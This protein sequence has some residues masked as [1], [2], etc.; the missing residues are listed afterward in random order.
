MNN[1]AID[2]KDFM[3]ADSVATRIAEQYMQWEMARRE[4]AAQK[5]ELRNY[6]F[7]IDTRT[8]NSK[9]LPWKNTTH[10]PKLCQIR[11][12][13][14]ANYM[15]A[16]FP[17]DRS[18]KWEGDDQEA[19]TLEK[20][21]VVEMYIRNKMHQSGFKNTMSQLLLDY[22]DT[23]NCFATVEYVRE[24]HEDPAT[25]EKILGY[26]G[27]K[28]YRI[29][30]NDIVF[31]PK[32]A[33]F[34]STAKI[35]RKLT[36]L[37]SLK[38]YIEKH[39][40]AEHLSGVFN[41]IVTNR[42]Q[43]NGAAQAD[44]AMSEAYAM[45]GFGTFMEYMQ[46]DYVEILTFYGD[47]YDR[48]TDTLYKNHKIVVVDRAYVLH[49]G[50]PQTWRGLPP[51]FHT[52]W[53]QRPDNLYAMGPLDNLVGMQHRIDH[54]E[55]AKA[56]AYDLIIHPVIKIKGLVEDFEYGP[57]ARIYVGDEGDA[58]FMR[59]DVT[60]LNADTQIMMYEAKMEEMAGAPKQAMGFRTPGEKTAYEVQV[61]EN[62]ANKVF[63][64]KAAHYEETFMEPILNAMLE[65][66]R[67]NMEGN[68]LVRTVDDQF[69]VVEF[70]KITKEDNTAKG[71]I[72][73]IGA[74]HFARN[75][76]IVQNLNAFMGSPLG[77]DPGVRNH[78]SGLRLARLMEELLDLERYDLVEENIQLD[79]A[80]ESQRRIGAIEQQLMEEGA[81]PSGQPAPPGTQNG[82][83]QGP[84]PRRS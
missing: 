78:L 58:E 24:E 59:P 69:N 79:E 6:L 46:S 55:N 1:V 31:D 27:P 25:S 37:P 49:K 56:D 81:I 44:F 80:A 71:K 38:A 26:V 3:N 8:T 72:R 19:E 20:R 10:L 16:I 17:H 21:K 63:I 39:P 2:I 45:D 50:P 35:I 42:H 5:R 68:E 76:N 84:Q 77:Q 73:P 70:Q 62:G 40:E 30:Y 36:T 65:I 51:V 7:A 82:M 23:G 53:R 74:R 29:S 14:H 47:L 48:D 34:Y 43:F 12:N 75:A 64:N 61:L 67:R 41:R 54:L 13:L 66:G 33:D 57:D 32:A 22:I 11:D 18:I 52:G 60:M 28:L 9:Q 83:D 4:W 15:A